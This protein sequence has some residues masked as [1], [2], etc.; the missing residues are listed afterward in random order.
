MEAWLNFLSGKS[1]HPLPYEQSRE[2]MLLTFAVISSIRSAA[3][4]QVF[5]D[6]GYAGH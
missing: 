3:S 2:S 1:Q 4:V 5:S 6:N